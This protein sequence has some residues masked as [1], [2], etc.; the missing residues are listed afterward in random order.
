MIF[1]F[2]FLVCGYKQGTFPLQTVGEW[3]VNGPVAHTCV[4]RKALALFPVM[5]LASPSLSTHLKQLVSDIQAI[6]TSVSEAPNTAINIDIMAR[7]DDIYDPLLNIGKSADTI[8]PLDGPATYGVFDILV[9]DI[10]QEDLKGMISEYLDI[11]YLSIPTSPFPI[12]PA[13]GKVWGPNRRCFLT[14]PVSFGDRVVN[15]HFLVMTGAPVSYL[16]ESTFTALGIKTFDVFEKTVRL[17]GV[18]HQFL[19]SDEAGYTDF[20]GVWHGCHF[21]GLNLLGTD[22]LY[23]MHGILTI[24]MPSRTVSLNKGDW[25]TRTFDS[26]RFF[27]KNQAWR[28]L[29]LQAWCSTWNLHVHHF[30]FL[31][32]VCCGYIFGSTL[33]REWLLAFI[34]PGCCGSM[35]TA[36]TPKLFG[37]F[38]RTMIDKKGYL[39]ITEVG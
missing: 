16:A 9:S 17:N 34:L 33:S 24:H 11:P 22:F 27:L 25:M 1:S 4:L 12:W 23:T 14:L 31:S 19:V 2:T 35:D 32:C 39:D 6:R 5:G 7:I 38:V 13:V 3:L 10:K 8:G 28:R 29:K 37:P 36:V 21:K 15:A 20:A 30:G 18:V 26:W